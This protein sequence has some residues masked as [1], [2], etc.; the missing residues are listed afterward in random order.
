MKAYVI[1][2]SRFDAAL[3]TKLLGPAILKTVAVAES[4]DISSSISLARSA[5]AVRQK[6]IAFFAD[7][8]A[9]ADHAIERRRQEIGELIGL[10]AGSTPF[11]VILAVPEIEVLFFQSTE[12]AE[13]IFG[14]TFSGTELEFAQLQP[15]KTFKELTSQRSGEEILALL[16]EEDVALMSNAPPIQELLSFLAQ[17][18]DEVET[19]P[20]AKAS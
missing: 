9:L 14:K 10:A 2:E 3:L 17:L 13:R 7:S 8:D 15:A 1:A 11:K 5:I 16:N 6:P 4:G 19:E 12:M 18:P 20:F